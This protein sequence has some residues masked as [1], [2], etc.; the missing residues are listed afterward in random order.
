MNLIRKKTISSFIFKMT[1]LARK[2]LHFCYKNFIQPRSISEDD[3]R[4]E[5]LLNII[6]CGFIGFITALFL[7]LLGYHIFL[8]TTDYEVPVFAFVIFIAVF[9]G[10]LTLSRKGYFDT[11][12]YVFLGIYFILTTWGIVQFGIELPLAMVSYVMIVI[13]AGILVSARFSFLSTC[14]IAGTLILN[15]YFQIHGITHPDTTWKSI[16][17]LI[18]D[19][20]ELGVAF[21]LIVI[22]TWLSN[23]EIESSL[24]R[25]RRSEQALTVERDNL[26]I[27]VQE[28]TREIKS[29]QAEKVAQLYHSAEFGRLSSGLFHDLMT[30]LHALV[31][32]IEQLKTNPESAPDVSK[33]LEK[34]IIASRR[35]G[36]F[37]GSIRKQMSRHD[38]S[39][40]FSCDKELI[41]TI[42]IL[43]YRARESHVKIS[44]TKLDEIELF[45]NPLKFH[46]ITINLVAN[47]IDSYKKF[48]TKNATVEV[49]L[50]KREGDLVLTVK[51][52]GCGISEE[53]LEKIFDPF[54][55]TK[56]PYHGTGL[57]L[58]T[59]KTIVE[60][61]FGGSIQATSQIGQGS[62]F[63]VVIPLH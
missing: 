39:E 52:F 59:T 48:D 27:T 2:G 8:G 1:T 43:A 63:I 46:Q 26:E 17:I 40:K 51:D 35:V 9:V 18:S 42:S 15:G 12:R 5:Y 31:G 53:F 22:L 60:Q 29:L 58:S 57:G 10:L 25:A 13:M 32:S 45:G 47:A 24:D 28:R 50:V 4:H 44:I 56:D 49:S 38:I 61:D 30:P 36:S 21:F 23:R 54:F 6:L 41:E 16:P 34:S 37:L 62:A 3:R 20:I 55:T 19:P 11:V 33:Y 14:V 7:F